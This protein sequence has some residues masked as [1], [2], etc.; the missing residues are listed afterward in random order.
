MILKKI[1]RDKK[2]K[3][4]KRKMNLLEAFIALA[5]CVFLILTSFSSAVP[6]EK[7]NIDYL[8]EDESCDV[9]SAING[10]ASYEARLFAD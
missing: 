8:R 7:D 4:K 6:W 3:N 10:G 1:K 2:M 9:L 5:I